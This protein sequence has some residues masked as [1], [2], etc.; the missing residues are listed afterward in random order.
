[1]NNQIMHIIT[2][3]IINILGAVIIYL[4]AVIVKYFKEKRQ[5]LIK[6]MGNE[7][8]NMH[9]NIAKSIFYAVEQE[10]KDVPKCS[11]E[12]AEKFDKMLMEKIP[13]LTQED[14]NHFREA[15]V[16]E[17]NSQ[18]AKAKLLEPSNSMVDKEK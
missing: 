13:T 6:K 14:L 15:I 2:D 3:A 5:A 1:M 9:Y 17:I 8:Y 10:Y 7:Q 16:G 12:K 4:S 18:I 11:K